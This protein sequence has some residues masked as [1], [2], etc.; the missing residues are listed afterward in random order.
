MSASSTCFYGSSKGRPSPLQFCCVIYD[1]LP[2]FSL[3]TTVWA[4][5]D[6]HEIPKWICGC[7]NLKE[8]EN[9]IYTNEV[10]IHQWEFILNCMDYIYKRKVFS[11]FYIYGISWLIE[12]LLIKKLILSYISVILLAW[13]YMAFCMR[14]IFSIVMFV[15]LT[16]G[17]F[18]IQDITTTGVQ[19]IIVICI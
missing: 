19:Y 3:L 17:V 7:L 13:E 4:Y 18:I 1:W 16:K 8:V 9:V 12:L 5:I 15:L 6:F 10:S 11:I 2:Y 14:H